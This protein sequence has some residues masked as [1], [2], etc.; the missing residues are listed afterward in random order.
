MYVRLFNNKL[1]VNILVNNSTYGFNYN[2]VM[3]DDYIRIVFQKN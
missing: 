1:F 3:D 2:A